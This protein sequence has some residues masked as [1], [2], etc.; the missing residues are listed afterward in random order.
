MKRPAL[1]GAAGGA[2][3]IRKTLATTTPAPVLQGLRCTACGSEGR[4]PTI[5]IPPDDPQPALRLTFLSD[6]PGLL[7]APRCRDGQ[8]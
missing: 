4:I 2:Q 1:P 5:A 3:I 6:G 7:C 8:A